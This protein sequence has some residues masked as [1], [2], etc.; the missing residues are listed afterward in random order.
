MKLGVAICA[1]RAKDQIRGVIRQYEG[2]ADRI[3]VAVSRRSWMNGMADNGTF[4]EA[5]DTSAVVGYDDW[6]NEHEQRNWC[7]E[8][9]KDMDYVIMSHCDTY[10][11]NDDLLKLKQMKLTDL[12][13]GCRVLTYWKDLDTVIDPDVSLPTIIIRSDAKFNHLINIEG[14]GAEPKELPITCYHLSWI[15]P[16]QRVEDKIRSYSH[17]NEIPKDWLDKVWDSDRTTNLAPTVP[18]D[19]QGLRN[20]PLP[21]EI[22]SYL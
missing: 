8:H 3:V 6:K 19:Y 11:T 16:K 20:D 10:F 13:Y 7:M 12:H 15:G 9:M 1:F 21:V 17:A 5:I 4:E 2:V 22:R 14:M 18:K